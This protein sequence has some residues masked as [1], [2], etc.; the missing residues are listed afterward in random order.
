MPRAKLARLALTS[1][2]SR[3]ASALGTALVLVAASSASRIVSSSSLAVSTARL[4]PSSHHITFIARAASLFR[5]LPAPA[6]SQHRSL[7]S[8]NTPPTLFAALLL[9]PSSAASA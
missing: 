9:P 1:R 7:A 4:L 5:T 8:L 3:S 2:R 6:L